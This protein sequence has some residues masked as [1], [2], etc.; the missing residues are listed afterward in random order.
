[1]NTVIVIICIYSGKVICNYAPSLDF[2][3]YWELSGVKKIAS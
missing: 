3:K 2:K 1:M